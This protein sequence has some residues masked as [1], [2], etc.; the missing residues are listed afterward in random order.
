MQILR[1]HNGWLTTQFFI[2][3]VKYNSGLSDAMF[4]REGLEAM[5]HGSKGKKD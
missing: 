5:A 3:E 1:E 2:E 4:T